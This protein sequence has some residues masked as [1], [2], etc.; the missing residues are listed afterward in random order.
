MLR[1]TGNA[2]LLLSSLSPLLPQETR[3]TIL[4]R[5]SDQ[6]GAV[7]AGASVTAANTATGVTANATT[8]AT[9]DFLIPFLIP[10]PYT[11]T[12][13]AAGFKT[14]VRTPIETR[15]NDRLTIDIALEVGQA[16]E[17]VHV[18]AE[19]ALLDT[20]TGSMG[21]VINSKMVLDL[22]L[23]AGN[24]TVMA[25]LA[26]GVIFTP[27]FPKDVRPFDTGSGSAIGGDGT[28]VGNAQFM[29]DGAMNNANSGFAYSPPPGVVQ[30]VKVQTASFDA[31]TGFM[32]GVVVNMS[33]KSG[34]N[35]LHGQSYYFNQNPAVA[36]NEFFRNRAGSPKLTYKAHRWGGNVSGP[37]ELPKLYDGRNR[38]FFM[39]GYEGFWS[40]DPVS[41][42][43]EAVPSPAQRRGDF[44]QLL[45]LGSRYQIYNPF[46][47][48]PSGN[49]LFSRQ[50][51]PNNII[52]SSQIDPLGAK[53]AQLY[54]L[55]N[56]AGNADG[57]NN[58][59][60][61]RN[62]HDNY[63]N[64]IVKIDH[65]FS[66]KQR[67]WF[68]GNVTRNKR[69]QDQRHSDTVGHLLYRYNRGLAADHVYTLSP[70]TVINT[71]YSYT[72]YIDGLDPDQVG[73][74]LTGLGFSSS[75]VNQIKA[76]NPALVR[77]PQIAAAGYSTLSV[78]SQ[79]RNPVDTHDFGVNVTKIA[80]SHTLRFGAGYRVYRRNSYDYGQSAGVLTFSTNWTRGP[81]D[82]SAASPIGQ[83]MASLLYG[84]PTGGNFPIN[85]S[86]AE[87][88]KIFSSYF[89][90][91]WK[92]TRKLT[93]SLGL[94]HELPSP[95]TERFN[96][97]VKGFDFNAPSPIE[98][99]V[100]AKYATNPI[101]QISA[102]QFKVR[103]GL[104]YPGV[105]GESVGLWQPNRKN[106][107]P[108]IGFAYSITPSFILR[109]GFGI[110]FEPIGVP[111]QNVIQTGFSTTTQLVP[112]L[113][114]GQHFIATLANPFPSGFQL[115]TGAANGLSQNLGQAIS[116]FTRNLANPY[117]ERWQ[118]AVQR[119]L[120]TS[121]VLEVSYV[122]NRGVRLR[123]ARDLDAIPNQY[124][125][126]SPT[127][128]QA[129]INLLSAQVPNPFYPLL[130]GTNLSGT[131][132][133]RSQLLLPYPQ[134]TSVATE[135]SQGY[136]W[137][138]S[139]QSRFEKRFGTGFMTTVSHT[140][141]KSMEARTV[142]NP[143]D[144]LPERVIS[145]QDRTHRIVVTT[146]Y[147][148]PFGKGRRFAPKLPAFAST[149]ISG[150]QASG[151]YQ[152]QSGP[153]LGFGNA[154]FNGNLANIPIPNGQRTVDRWFNID[155]GFERNS[156]L[157]LSQNLQ[158][159]S[160]RFSG[161]R[162]DGA[163]N[164]DIS[165]LKNTTLREGLQ[166]QFRIDAINALNHTQFLPPNTTPSSSAFGQVTGTWASPRTVLFAVKLLF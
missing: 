113:D 135:N 92:I 71:R 87:Q 118:L 96:R 67:I 114:N 17:S 9:G 140:W 98:A 162:G 129:T 84:L 50:P 105:G 157:Q 161:I 144:P 65:N 138:H 5:V 85:D 95:M 58:Y 34:T 94:R 110:Y 116:F 16:S 100:R 56:L 112:T 28:R 77:F 124:L 66:I 51:L 41:I 159:L 72:R 47:I 25:N 59:T 131:T 83:G 49:G 123:L 152:G 155:A 91:D 104:T 149:L 125:S 60:N 20:S 26:P 3:S 128:D 32:T 43:F 19:T 165:L 130:P 151:I 126:T 154:I 48:A 53:V 68:R 158:T 74:D 163:N 115:P 156:A 78:Q 101:P 55:P 97:S 23:I 6:S 15:V 136:A 108:R 145:D 57:V 82:T 139:L 111:N 21:Q 10:G 64:H 8:N 119:S 79:N 35:R 18:T 45:A 153:P 121:S 14:W 102:D 117:S 106:F 4:G 90:D 107:M 132:V 12:V 39:Y 80:S 46:S 37:I 38:T 143:G 142:R 54:D 148:L 62:S 93:L 30:E 81:F 141:S 160:T 61:G 122:G 99:V 76:V 52:P 86:Y 127:R 164:W 7:I 147:E 88:V 11:L 2:L 24:V 13:E 33:L 40:F 109:G 134:F 22:P 146:V 133:A 137:Y 69:I 73:A 75:F 29:V 1:R 103:G 63:Y 89:Q 70:S 27:T 150:W 44:S 31:S 166:L 42:G 36:A 120:G